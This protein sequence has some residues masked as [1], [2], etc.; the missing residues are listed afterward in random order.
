MVAR[1]KVEK[2]QT[3]FTI[4]PNEILQSK[5]LSLQA[6]GLISQ[7]LSFPDNWNYSINGLVAVVKEGRTAVMNTIKELERYG[8]VKRNKIHDKNGKFSGIEYVITDYPNTDSPTTE[9]PY[10][11]NPKMVKTQ[12]NQPYAG[13]PTTDKPTMVKPTTDKPIA[14]NLIQNN[15]IYN[16]TIYK[17]ENNIKNIVFDINVINECINSNNLEYVNAEE[18]YNYYSLRDWKT[19]NGEPITNLKSLLVSWNTRNKV[20]VEE[21]RETQRKMNERHDY[22]A[23]SNNVPKP[24]PLEVP[25]FSPENASDFLNKLAKSGKRSTVLQ[26]IIGNLAKEKEMR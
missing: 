3:N 7:C 6:K 4:I 19:K 24:A 5:E 21:T 17:K 13:N 23:D 1:I 14:E 16:N 12:E 25:E 26:S 8:Y 22:A 2:K 18:F 10:S 15:T 9:K 11:E 20:R